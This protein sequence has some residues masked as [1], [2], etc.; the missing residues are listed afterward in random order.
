MKIQ[1]KILLIVILL[2]MQSF[3]NSA[4]A[5]DNL[6]TVIVRNERYS[7]DAYILTYQGDEKDRDKKAKKDFKSFI[8]LH[9]KTKKTSTEKYTYK[10]LLKLTTGEINVHSLC[11]NFEYAETDELGE[12][13]TA[14]IASKFLPA[15]NYMIV[16]NIFT[17]YISLRF[18]LSQ[19]KWM[20]RDS[21]HSCIPQEVTSEY[22]KGYLDILYSNVLPN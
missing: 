16:R 4:A 19:D 7:R 22:L 21:N 17:R 10:F 1:N 15:H 9:K 11:F 6:Y 13:I 5:A 18:F 3:L 20:V 12:A 8:I 14:R 2:N